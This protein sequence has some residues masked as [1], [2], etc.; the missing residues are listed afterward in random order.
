MTKT[1]LVHALLLISLSAC[2]NEPAVLPCD[3]SLETALAGLLDEL[4]AD[5]LSPDSAIRQLAL[6]LPELEACEGRKKDSLWASVSDELGKK[7][8][9]DKP[10]DSELYSQQALKIRKRLLDDPQHRDIMRMYYNIGFAHLN[11]KNYHQAISY[12]DSAAA[13]PIANLPQLFVLSK[14]RLGQA[15]LEI[16]ELN[17]A[18]FHY[19]VASD[20]MAVYP[21]STKRRLELVRSFASCYRRLREYDKGIKKAGE[22]MSQEALAVKG[23]AIADLC[24]ALGNI[25]Q[26]SLLSADGE[27]ARQQ[28]VFYTQKAL[29]FYEEMPEGPTKEARIAMAAGNLGELYRRM[30]QFEEAVRVLT[31]A[32]S[33]LKAKD[34]QSSIFVSLY[35][36]RGETHFGEERYEAALA[37][38]DSALI[39]LVP[40][41]PYS[42]GRPLPAVHSYSG[43]HE[44]SMVLL[45]DIA[46]TNLALFEKKKEDAAL[47]K[48]AVAA[49][50]TL[51]HLINLVRGDFISDEAKL[52]LAAGSRKI[53]GKAFQG[54]LLLYRKTNE[55]RYR[56][57][58]F[59]ISEQSKAFVLLEAARLKHVSSM[60]PEATRQ[61]EAQLLQA[62]ANIEGQLLQAWDNPDEKKR[63]NKDLSRNFEQIRA[64]QQQLKKKHANYYALKYQ[65]ANLSSTQ[66]REELLGEG[67]SLVE[68][69]YQD[70]FLHLFLLAPEAIEWHTVAISKKQLD[71]KIAR[72]REL[73]ERGRPGDAGQEA[74]F[75]R[76]AHNLYRYLLAPV[77][78]KLTERLIIIPAGP[79]NNLPYETLLKRQ[80]TGGIRQQLDEDN[81]VLFSHSIS[82]CFSANLLSL[83]QSGRKSTSRRKNMAVFAT[84]FGHGA[85][86]RPASSGL[87]PALLKALPFLTPLGVNQ[88][89]EVKKIEE[90]IR[91]VEVFR[92]EGAS[93]AAFL[94]AC[95]QYAVLHIPTHGILNEEDPSYSF[96][97]FSQMDG[98]INPSEL[99]FVKDLYA[100]RWDIDLIFLSA[101]QTASGRFWE[102]EGN[103]SLAR[104]MAYAGVRS[105]ATTLWNVPTAAKSKIAPAFYIHYIKE[106]QPKDVALAEAKRSVARQ[107]HPKDWAGLILVG[108]S[109]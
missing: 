96:I 91:G 80:P 28:A 104:G 109:E 44:K 72:F 9:S 50:D 43:D 16:G 66:I 19:Q 61:K 95:R 20:S 1:L 106:G 56:E 11:R 105:L 84:T 74:E 29:S 85:S 81:F 12:F 45:A 75:C 82:Y 49:Y 83:M 18:L 65:G 53:L 68:Y 52:E 69:F 39:F 76:L 7:L 48:K 13:R 89:T 47:L 8:L 87:P 94:E 38:Y 99:L 92:G 77:E 6:L 17:N 21:G 40:S 62:R 4:A 97:S 70:S 41:Y 32:I 67:Q 57:E 88:E 55:P 24:L 54:C 36:N 51:Y 93:K 22:G 63:L 103:I 58:A 5:S 3:A 98:G 37:D 14:L 23:I 46:L 108:A 15:Y 30:G 73:L 64:F 59:R 26:D 90:S 27:E 100:Q 107:Y 34:S 10:V 101:C 2:K 35:I 25:W 60:L 71:H 42:A 78:S 86:Q 33:F 79:L 102:G 31:D